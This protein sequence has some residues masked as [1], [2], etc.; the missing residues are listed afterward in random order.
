[1]E[2]EETSAETFAKGVASIK[3]S[4]G[5][6]G[7]GKVLSDIWDLYLAWCVERLEDERSCDAL[8]KKVGD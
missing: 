7:C 6:K 2:V 3:D 5:E 8:R 1:M 4:L